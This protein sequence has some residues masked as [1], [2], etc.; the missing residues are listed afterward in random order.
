M[1]ETRICEERIQKHAISRHCNVTMFVLSTCQRRPIV[2][3]DISW[4]AELQ[5]VNFGITRKW[6]S[7]VYG[8]E[9]K[10]IQYHGRCAC[11][12]DIMERTWYACTQKM[13]V[14]T[15]TPIDK[16]HRREREMNALS[17]HRWGWGRFDFCYSGYRQIFVE[18]IFTVV[19]TMIFFNIFVKWEEVQLA[20]AVK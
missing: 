13:S 1:N 15:I 6:W 18:M 5:V 4:L 8:R 3:I 16:P 12:M 9:D 2:D 20:T 17:Y 11:T 10:Q 7:Q 14:L 19:G